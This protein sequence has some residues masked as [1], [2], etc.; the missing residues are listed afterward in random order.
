[1]LEDFRR[2]ELVRHGRKQPVQSRWRQDKGHRAEWAAFVKSVQRRA[3]SPI[4]FDEIV[5]S[6]LATL[7]IDESIATR[8]RLSVD[9]ADFLNSALQT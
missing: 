1:V 3:E 6:T 8:G 5:C 7:R 9:T 4:G 2:L